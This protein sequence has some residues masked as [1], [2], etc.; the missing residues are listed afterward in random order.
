MGR[1]GMIVVD[2][3][4]DGLLVGTSSPVAVEFAA[5]VGQVVVVL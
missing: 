4:V 1:R 2:D 3:V 5:V